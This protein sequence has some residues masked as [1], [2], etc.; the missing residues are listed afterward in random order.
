MS[1][2]MDGLKK[3]SGK[4]YRTLSSVNAFAVEILQVWKDFVGKY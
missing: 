3:L 2:V 4:V 1:I